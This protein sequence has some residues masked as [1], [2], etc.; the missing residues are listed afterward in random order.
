MKVHIWKTSTLILLFVCIILIAVLSQSKSNFIKEKKE[1]G[2]F[3]LNELNKS[4]NYAMDTVIN[5]IA[6]NCIEYHCDSFNCEEDSLAL[7]AVSQTCED[8]IK[9]KPYKE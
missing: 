8:I 4:V 5:K 9:G 6:E 7:V 1:L 2:E 3:C